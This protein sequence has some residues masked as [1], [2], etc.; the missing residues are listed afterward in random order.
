MG[1]GNSKVN[2]NN[3]AGTGRSILGERITYSNANADFKTFD[4]RPVTGPGEWD[5]MHIYAGDGKEQ[6]K[7]VT[8]NTNNMELIDEIADDYD[9]RDAFY[10]YG[11]GGL[12]GTDIYDGWD[13]ESE[14]RKEIRR[15][16][17]EYIDRSEI[18][19]SVTVS[20]LSDTQ[21]LFGKGKKTAT[22]AEVQAMEGELI[23]SQN[24]L[25]SG[26]AAEGLRITYD[27]KPIEYKIKIP[28]GSKG[29]GMW[30]G[31]ERINGWGTKQ[32]EFLT[33]RDV[34]YRVGKSYMDKKR[35]VIVCEITFA[36]LDVHD[37]GHDDI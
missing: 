37:Y 7:W 4:D 9:A 17:D 1:R 10:R 15:H 26:M 3:V 24:N 25:S 35:G 19:K 14:H 6:E 21:L 18:Q 11:Q 27:T 33:N 28:G 29:A 30:I 32:L 8:E 12:M 5:R 31:D 23:F 20:R 13:S 22:L 2:N 34:W 36:S 16:L